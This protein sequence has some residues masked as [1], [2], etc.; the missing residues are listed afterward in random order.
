MDLK[1]VLGAL[2]RRWF[3]PV[4][5]VAVALL[6]ATGWMALQTP[7]YKASAQVFVSSSS[8]ASAQV[9]GQ[10]QSAMFAQN[11]VAT[12][13]Q[14][15]SSPQVLDPVIQ[16]LGL[17]A[18]ARDIA[19]SV[20]AVNPPQTVLL[21]VT[22]TSSSAAQAA[23]LANATGQRLAD[24]IE[25]L[26]TASDKDVSPIKVTV[27]KPAVPPSAP[28]SPNPTTTLGLA[29][30]LGLALGVGLAL[31]REQLDTTI[32]GSRELA[33]LSGATPLGVIGFD[34]DAEEE[35]LA[36]LNQQALRSEAFR[37]I[38]TNLS[39]TDVDNPPKVV[40]I[41]SSVPIEG[42]ST[43]A[44]NLAITMAQA[45]LRVCLVEADLRRPR[46]AQYLGIDSAVGLTDVLAGKI[47]LDQALLPWNRYLFTVLPSGAIPPNPSELLASG[48]M[49]A[50]LATLRQQ[51]DVVVVDTAPLLAV[52]D[53]AI[54]ASAADGA[55]LMV[56][57][58]KTTTDQL[59][60]A[61]DA[62]AQV[63]A[64]L[65]GTVL[66]YTPS[67]KR[68]GYGYSGYGYGYGYGSSYGDRGETKKKRRFRRKT[69]APATV[70]ITEAPPVQ[71]PVDS[72][73]R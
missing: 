60:K 35:P 8:G 10:Y 32:K 39:Y 27:T 1:H 18:T 15:V 11:R 40:A 53:G 6:L 34:P 71:P 31:L 44:C 54:T 42:K 52:A 28:F 73:S 67:K 17:N 37:T 12:Y 16:D 19:G 43:A 30:L 36:A 45:G 20:S 64:H 48:Q 7:M 63:D 13:A 9:G 14:L 69:K 24:A 29:G 70:S 50:T 49:K 68:S 25:A 59:G 55:I 3:F 4:I 38:R 56:R 57:Y 2:R 47:T 65:L 62:L 51:F 46:I 33:E 41:T 61:F 5:S 21:E 66:N 22:A 58:G 72:S 23:A 26:E